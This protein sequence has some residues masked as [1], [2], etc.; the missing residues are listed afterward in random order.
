MSKI[1]LDVCDGYSDIV[2]VGRY[3]AAATVI[4]ARPRCDSATFAGA[5]RLL[6]RPVWGGRGVGSQRA[7]HPRTPGG[8]AGDGQIPG[9]WGDRFT[10]HL[11]MN[12][13]WL[14]GTPLAFNGYNNNN[15]RRNDGF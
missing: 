15:N 7:P 5:P 10:P 4:S 3:V 1:R 2:V 12:T 11:T 14:V 8:D 6:M 13:G 9:E